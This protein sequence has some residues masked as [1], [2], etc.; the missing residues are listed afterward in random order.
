MTADPRERQDWGETSAL[1]VLLAL[2][3]ALP[4]RYTLLDGTAIPTVLLV[5][6]SVTCALSI[7]WSI[8]G[9]R[10]WT[11]LILTTVAV[12]GG[13]ALVA[14]LS[15]V[16]TLTVYGAATVDGVRLLESSIWLWISNIVEFALVYHLIDDGDFVFQGKGPQPYVPVFLDYVFLAFSTSTAF[17]ATDTPPL[18]TRA[19]MLMM[20]EASI[21]LTTIAIGAAR[22]V[23]IL[24]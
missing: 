10:R 2:F 1:I 6:L 22:A 3:L 17:S 4:N 21:A 13:I 5:V 15:K 9:R 14:T 19:R 24:H 12:V 16:V 23:N 7:F 8:A 18:T 20:L 11:R